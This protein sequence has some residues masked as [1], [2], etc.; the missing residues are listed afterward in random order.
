MADIADRVREHAEK[1]MRAAGSSLQ[2][3]T[4]RSHADILAAVMDCY[5]AAFRAGAE[6]AQGQA[7]NDGDKR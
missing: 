6:F 4:T 5:E 1:I 3:Y 7:T 2:H